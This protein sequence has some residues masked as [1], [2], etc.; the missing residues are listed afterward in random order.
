MSNP[1]LLSYALDGSGLGTA[2]HDGAV[3]HLLKDDQFA[4]AHLNADQPGT[5]A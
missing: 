1:V 5:A 3:S 4:W 2:L